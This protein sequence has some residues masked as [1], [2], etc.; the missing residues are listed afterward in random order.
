M[1]KNKIKNNNG[2]YDEDKIEIIEINTVKELISHLNLKLDKLRVFKDDTELSKDTK[3]NGGDILTTIY[4]VDENNIFQEN[5]DENLKKTIEL[6]INGEKKYINYSKD[7]FQFVDVFDH[8]DF[9]LKKTKGNL[10][11][12]V[13][14]SSA[15]YMQDL[16][17]GDA[18]KIY[19]ES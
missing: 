6:S 8:I 15:E 2:F 18:L 12:E 16:K 13:N 4:K 5:N 14:G 17:N 7:S 19:W 9:D 10:I 1:I 3:L 11:L